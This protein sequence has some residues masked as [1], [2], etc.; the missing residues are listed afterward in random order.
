M[1]IKKFKKD[2][3]GKYKVFFNDNISYLLYDDTIIKYNLLSKKEITDKLFNEIIKYNSFF[4]YY[5]KCIKYISTKMRTDK[6]IEKYLLKYN[7]EKNII[8][9]IISLLYERGF[10]NK[11]NYLIAFVNDQFNLTK[12][13]PLK[14]KKALCDLGYSDE[15]IETH[16]NKYD[17]NIR[18]DNLI[19]KKIKSNHNLS[20]K[21]LKN[22]LLDELIRLGYEKSE[23]SKYLI[24]DNIF[25][26]D[27]NILEKELVKV[28]RKYERKYDSYE[29]KNKVI[30]YLYKKGF[31]IEKI[32][33][34]YDEK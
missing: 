12:N 21:M 13:G 15:E 2:K 18:I 25:L 29:L 19:H 31:E 16:L 5:N 7:V 10:L 23:I 32:K 27:D 28:L 14:I 34:L 8:S 6:E 3:S 24:N 33:R 17:W 4:E 26:E 1:K 30:N 20:N 9:D 22:K 11:N